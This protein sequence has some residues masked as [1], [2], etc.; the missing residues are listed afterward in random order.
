MRGRTRLVFLI[1]AI[2]IVAAAGYVARNGGAKAARAPQA[3][4]ET[5]PA[6]PRPRPLPAILL[7]DAITLPGSSSRPARPAPSRLVPAGLPGGAFGAEDGLP[8]PTFAGGCAPGLEAVPAP[9]AMVRLTLSAP[10][11]AGRRVV[12][13]HA[14]L[15]FAEL[16]DSAGRLSVEVPLLD[17]AA[18]FRAE[19]ADGAGL[20]VRAPDV[21]GADAYERVAIAWSG[22]PALALHALEAGAGSG[23]SGHARAEA[24]DV[25]TVAG[26][27]LT[28]LGNP[29]IENPELALVYSFPRARGE[30]EGSV[31]VLAEAALTPQSC[32]RAYAMSALQVPAGGPPQGMEVRFALPECGE[33]AGYIQLQNLFRDLKIARNRE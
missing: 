21:A 18:V 15:R 16:T 19:L 20:Q 23:G 5:W 3:H 33:E 27:V 30:G 14:G 32:G 8:G 17:P 26:G 11:H 28:R 22:P 25:P 6:P 9:G 31:R 4:V 7:D 1:A 29:D 24:A 12:L 10:C 13:S 2:G